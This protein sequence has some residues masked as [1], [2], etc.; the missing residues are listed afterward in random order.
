MVH[1]WSSSE[2]TKPPISG[3]FTPWNRPYSFLIDGWNSNT[4][5]SVVKRDPGW[6]SWWFEQFKYQVYQNQAESS[7]GW[8]GEKK[9]KK[10]QT[11]ALLFWQAMIWWLDIYWVFLQTSPSKSPNLRNF[12]SNADFLG[13]H[14]ASPVDLEPM[15]FLLS[16]WASVQ[17]CVLCND[18]HQPWSIQF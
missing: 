5:S 11:K 17:S 3:D 6:G 2:I 8:L 7:C 18:K 10:T 15:W 12:S 9:R 4:L 13:F 16:F 14:V 1:K